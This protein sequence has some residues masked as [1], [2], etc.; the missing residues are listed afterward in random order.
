MSRIEPTPLQNTAL[1]WLGLAQGAALY[2]LYKTNERLLWPVEWGPVF[3][4]AL[5]AVL[6]LPF[7]VYWAH[8]VLTRHA[9]LKLLL[10]M[11]IV[12]LG[13]GAY[14]AATVFPFPELKKPQLVGFPVFFSLSP[15]KPVSRED[16][17]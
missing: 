3:N 7:I 5:L 4:A 16:V 2:A 1:I 17:Q 14:Q 11:G 6:L 10:G 9:L 15:F 13:L 8:G 12:T